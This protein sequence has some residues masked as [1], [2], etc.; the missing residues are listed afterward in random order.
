[1]EY[2]N[3]GRTGTRVSEVGLGTMTFGREADEGASRAILDAYLEAGGNF[4]D[5]A[6]TYGGSKGIAEEII[7]RSLEGR[8]EEVVIATKVRF[9]TSP[10]PNDRGLSRRHIRMSVDAS[11]RRL[12]T[13]WIDLLQ[14]HSWDPTTPIDV[15]LS[16][17]DDLVTAGKVLHAGVSNFTGWQTAT[18]VCR[19]EM[20]SW[21]P[22]VTYQ[23]NYSLIGRELEREVIPF[24]I[25]SGLGVLCYGPL[26]GGL[27]TGKYRRGTPPDPRTRAGGSDLSAE[28]MSRRMSERA[29]A[30]ADVVRDVAAEV[31]RPPAHVAL[32]WVLGQP[33][34]TS[35]LIGARTVAQLDETLGTVGWSLDPELSDRLDA[36]SEHRVGYPQEFQSWMASIG[37]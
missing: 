34:I 22:I 11:L 36:A 12:R 5:T 7:G 15:T 32:G 17:L 6:N 29:F 35:A 19:G 3:L 28:G 23:G 18:A 20:R 27:L 37:M 10:A 13:G 16:A 14:L 1:M 8:R 31:G 33:G 30:I 25:D 2:R 21:A 9:A 24:C 26:A 4:I